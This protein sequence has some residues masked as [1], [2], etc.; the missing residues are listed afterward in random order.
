MSYNYR[1]R[2]RERF[3]IN[4]SLSKTPQIFK[5]NDDYIKPTD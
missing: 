4:D 1:E 5:E 3:C 2:E